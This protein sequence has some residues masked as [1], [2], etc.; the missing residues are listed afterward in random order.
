MKV[1]RCN[2]KVLFTSIWFF[3]LLDYYYNHYYYSILNTNAISVILFN[4][5]LIVSVGM[6]SLCQFGSLQMGMFNLLTNSKLNESFNPLH[7][8]SLQQQPGEIGKFKYLLI[9]HH[10]LPRFGYFPIGQTKKKITSICIPTDGNFP[11]F[12]NSTLSS[13]RKSDFIFPCIFSRIRYTV[14]FCELWPYV[15]PFHSSVELQLTWST[16]PK[17]NRQVFRPTNRLHH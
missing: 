11:I 2:F 3:F 10:F 12:E 15:I 17:K 1:R 9:F 13:R 7:H 8:L 4:I 14:T 5:A 6:S 16:F